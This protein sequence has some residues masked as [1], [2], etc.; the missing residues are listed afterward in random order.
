MRTI[1]LQLDE[2]LLAGIGLAARELGISRSAFIRTALQ[3]AL[4]RR[5]APRREERH[6][7]G[8]AWHPAVPGEFSGWEAEQAWGRS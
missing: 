6:R 7:K 4:R 1:R 8:Y 5:S 2:R 3:E